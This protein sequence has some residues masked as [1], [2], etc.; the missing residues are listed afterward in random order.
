MRTLLEDYERNSELGE[1]FNDYYDRKTEKYFYTLLKPL[2]D[3]STLQSG[4]FVDWGHEVKFETAIGVGECAGEVVTR[5][6]F[7]L[8]AAERLVFEAGLQLDGATEQRA[9]ETAY[10]AFLKA[11]RAL[12]Q[13]QYD[14]ISNEPEEIIAE[15]KRR[16]FDTQ[17]FSDPF[18]G[19]KFAN[20]LFAAHA[21]RGEQ[22][23]ADT[24]HHRI[25]EAQLFIEAVY[26][27]HNKLGSSS[28]LAPAKA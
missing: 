14:D 8:T 23:T 10:A 19:P 9:G 25:A 16:F 26:N 24:A 2:A 13:A 27:C 11:A 1:Y 20:F 22:F 15:F 5:F 21:G 4:D 12:V 3:L 6:Q 17:L 7:E 18:V 28:V